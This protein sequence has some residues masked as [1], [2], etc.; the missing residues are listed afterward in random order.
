MPPNQDDLHNSIRL[1]TYLFTTHASKR[2]AERLILSHEIE[3]AILSGEVIEDYPDDKYSP[4]CLILGYSQNKRA[5][6]IQVSYPP[7]VKIITVY[8]PS[9]NEWEA[10][11]KT[12]K[13][14]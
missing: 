13:T 6:H 12:R 9:P 5:L 3:E 7:N 4:S 11:L 10:N 1:R 2:A 14:P 8:E